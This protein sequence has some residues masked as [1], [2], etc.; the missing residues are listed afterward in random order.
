MMGKEIAGITKIAARGFSAAPFSPR[1]RVSVVKIGF[2][3]SVISV[4]QRW[5]FLAF[6]LRGG[7][8]PQTRPLYNQICCRRVVAQLLFCPVPLTFL[9]A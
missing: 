5:G 8:T 1:L 3:I 6:P 2:S 9:A 7:L 4:Y